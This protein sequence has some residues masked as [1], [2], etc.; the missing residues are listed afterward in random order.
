MISIPFSLLIAHFVGDF[1][2]QTNWMA[3]AKS[4]HLGALSLHVLIYSLCFSWWGPDFVVATFGLHFMVDY[5]TSKITSL[6][7]FF[8][9]YD[10]QVWVYVEGRRKWFFVMIG[11]DQLLHFT[12][13]A[14]T[15]KLL[16]KG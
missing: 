15:Y 5:I 8:E 3:T 6:L 13:L 10:D 12:C 14:I 16:M 11:F 1:P 7:F 4:K 2:L 9:P